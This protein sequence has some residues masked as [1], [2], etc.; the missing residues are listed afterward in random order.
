MADITKVPYEA[1]TSKMVEL[2]TDSCILQASIPGYGDS[3]ELNSMEMD[4]VM[5]L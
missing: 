5:I 2:K 4:S 1:P 3:I